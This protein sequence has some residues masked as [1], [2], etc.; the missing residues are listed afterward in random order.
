MGENHSR[1]PE[2]G[3]D[4]EHEGEEELDGDATGRLL[5]VAPS[6]EARF[7]RQPLERGQQR[8]AVTIGADEHAYQRMRV[9]A[10]G[11]G[12]RRQRVAHRRTAVHAPD[13]VVERGAPRR[14]RPRCD[15][16]ERQSQ[17]AAARH[18]EDEE[19]DDVGHGAYRRDAHPPLLPTVVQ[20]ATQ[21]LHR[22]RR[23][24]RGCGRR[25]T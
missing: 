20:R 1:E 7:V 19:I 6:L 12:Q 4:A 11:L 25:G 5:G 23:S 9:R 21:A 14:R 16:F 3:E 2:G 18:G 8:G 13:H 24:R 22:T 15:R 10:G 17:V